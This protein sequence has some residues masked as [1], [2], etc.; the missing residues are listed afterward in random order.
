MSYHI[1]QTE[2]FIID[3]IDTGEANKLVTLYTA[4]LG[5]IYAAA[6]SVRV[7]QSKLRQS[8]QDLSFASL[9]LVRGKELWRVTSS[10]KLISL[11]D[12]RIPV[13][14]RMVMARILAFVK[15]M[16]T[17]ESPNAELFSILSD[18]SAFCFAEREKIKTKDGAEAIELITQLRILDVLGYA[19]ADK[20]LQ[21]YL[22][23]DSKHGWADDLIKSM[24]DDGERARSEIAR[25]VR[26]SH[27]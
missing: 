25:A 27:L 2:G 12:R 26:E 14:G 21:K 1:Y 9:A 11:Y 8:L 6:Q 17:G 18:L 24:K 3:S 19:T 16:V 7:Q 22:K 15:R 20:T 5:L 10:R 23:R 4:D 13:A